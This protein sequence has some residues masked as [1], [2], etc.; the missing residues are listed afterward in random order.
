MTNTYYIIFIVTFISAIIFLIAGI[1]MFFLFNI[2]KIMGILTGFTA[3]KQIR[4]IRNRDKT[5]IA[6][7]SNHLDTFMNEQRNIAQQVKQH[8]NSNNHQTSVNQPV[9]N[10]APPDKTEFMQNQT[11]TIALSQNQTE[12]IALETVTLPYNNNVHNISNTNMPE[13]TYLEN[14]TTGNLEDKTE[15]IKFNIIFSLDFINTDEVI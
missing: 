7:N 13:T 8:D 1:V 5:A 15:N 3:R 2:P 14:E 12:T 9:K 6:N 10:T 4:N 11:E